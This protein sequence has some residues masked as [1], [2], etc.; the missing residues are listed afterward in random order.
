MPLTLPRTLWPLL[1]LGCLS[2]GT[3]TVSM[4]VVRP[5]VLN[6]GPYGGTVTVAGFQAFRPDL[7]MPAE[8]L[9]MDVAQRVR[10]SIGGVVRLQDQGGG[11]VVS[12]VMLDHGVV[13]VERNRAGKCTETVTVVRDGVRSQQAVERACVY[14]WYDWTA[15]V[16][17]HLRVTD[18]QGQ[19]MYLRAHSADRRGNTWE[20]KDVPNPPDD[21]TAVLA[22]LRAEV[23][24]QLAAVVAPH[25]VRVDAIFHDCDEPARQACEAGVK[26]FAA[27]DY[28]GAIRAFTDAIDR[29][30][31]ANAAVDSQAKAWWDRGIV[32]QYSRHFD[33]ALADFRKSC[34]LDSRGSCG[35][36][37]ASVETERNAHARLVDEGLGK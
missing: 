25:R 2:C 24:E 17:V 35:N 6:A 22:A 19:V 1:L 34:A 21:P 27:S 14:H 20:R 11:L 9:R 18:A 16:A 7:S 8:A 33:E 36:Q 32:N 26:L 29:L 10:Q 31:R 23:A 5:A 28:E 13:Y 3:S 4:M 30:V 12:G 37:M 15:R